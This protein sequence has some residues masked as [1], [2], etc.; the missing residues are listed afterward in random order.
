MA[1]DSTIVG[2]CTAGFGSNHKLSRS[3]GLRWNK[4]ERPMNG[5][6]G[7]TTTPTLISFRQTEE[8]C[9]SVPSSLRPAEGL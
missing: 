8:D 1:A 5:T 2:T 4:K 6:Q 7:D 3:A 9:S